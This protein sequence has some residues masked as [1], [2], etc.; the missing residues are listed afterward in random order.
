MLLTLEMFCSDMGLISIM[1]NMV[2]GSENTSSTLRW[3]ILHMALRPDV[4][5]DF[6]NWTSI[7]ERN[8]DVLSK[9]MAQR[10]AGAI[11]P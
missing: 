9:W 3:I 7:F 1:G 2:V 10:V 4:S 6:R 11:L 8:N 5:Y